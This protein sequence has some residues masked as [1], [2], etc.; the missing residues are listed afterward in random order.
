MRVVDEIRQKLDIVEVISEYVLLQK[1]GQNFQGLCPFHKDTHPSFYVFP[2]DQRWH[3][4]GCS[5]GGD[6]FSFVMKKEGIEFR[7]AIHMLASRAGVS[8]Q[9]PIEV[10][11]NLYRLNEEAAHFYHHF[12]RT[13]GKKACSYLAG[14]NISERSIL[15]FGLGFAPLE[16]HSLREHLLSL[17][18][19]R[20]EMIEGGLLVL[21][22]RGEED[23]FRGRLIF[24]IKDEGSR[25][26]GFGARA[27]DDSLPKYINSSKTRVF[28]KGSLLYGIDRAK[29][30]IKRG[31]RVVVVEGY[32][33]VIMAHQN[34]FSDVVA[35]MG[36]S[37]TSRQVSLLGRLT[38]NIVLALDADAAGKMATLR[39]IEVIG[40]NL[41]Q[42]VPI[43][44][45]RGK[46]KF[47]NE[48]RAELKIALIP[49]SKDPDELIQ[50]DPKAWEEITR[51]A[52]PAIDYCFDLALLELDLN[53]IEGR[54]QALDRLLPVVAKIKHPIKRSLYVQRLSRM[55][56]VTEDDLIS[57]LPPKQTQR[58]LRPILTK[59]ESV[60]EEY[61]L[62]L[63]LHYPKLKDRSIIEVEDYFQN[64]ES[65]EVLVALID[66]DPGKLK[67]VAIS[68]KVNKLKARDLPPLKD[69]EAEEVLWSSI[70]RLKWRWLK[71]LK[72]KE[73]IL[74]KEALV[75]GD[76]EE[77][78]RLEQY[79]LKINQMLKEVERK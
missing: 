32:M 28:D 9:P 57:V 55:V 69:E 59:D 14:R 12:L 8:L 36:T 75:D 31:G 6:V 62:T 15:D 33:D 21:G 61:L 67:D 22:E 72:L 41:T 30:S 68:E 50:K 3:C 76:K 34:G 44:D 45:S 26:C 4:F 7:D 74:L 19:S 53:T 77:M 47:E 51:E 25:V 58:N 64:A 56:E 37:L 54:T 43:P 73:E 24:P 66:E 71:D 63:V 49:G 65:K 29:E 11:S 20:E 23:R 13:S 78:A 38:S 39:G 1:R 46:V 27:L 42:V 60:M 17:N 40:D 16:A 2:Q 5:Q 10:S 79:G 35:S 52:R 18:F 48:S 70:H